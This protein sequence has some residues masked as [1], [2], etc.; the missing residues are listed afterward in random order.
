VSAPT[1]LKETFLQ[2]G[3]GNFLRAFADLF[4]SQENRAGR[5]AGRVVAVQSTGAERARELNERGCR[6]HVAVRGFSGGKVV[7]EVELADSISRV[8]VAA[9]EWDEVQKVASSPDLRWIL[10]NV[11]EAGLSLEE[12]DT[13]SDRPPSSFPAKLLLCLRARYDA[14]TGP[15][16]IVPCELVPENGIAVK[17]LVLAQ[18]ARWNCDDSF[19]AWLSDQCRW[20]NTLVDRIVPGR[21]ISHPLLAE[22]PLLIS[23]EPFAFWALEGKA[24]ELPLTGHPAVVAA[25]DITGY[26]L[27]KVRILNGAHTALVANA[28]PM[29]IA[30]VREA[31]EHPEVNDWLQRLLFEEIVP[32]L[33]GRVEEPELF[34]RQTLDRFANPFL[35]HKLSDIAKGHDGKMELRLRPTLA[36]FRERFGREPEILSSLFR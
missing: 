34:A 14:G 25:D 2:F 17:K 36:E 30:T 13:P 22:D 7:D 24:D 23:A 9:T 16:T 21:P 28:I 26:Q 10:S 12:K 31:V 32:V 6:Y 11:T 8:L 15:I 20:V 1:E 33:E 18:A 4:A 3:T 19:V 5:P 35:D 29:G 27:R